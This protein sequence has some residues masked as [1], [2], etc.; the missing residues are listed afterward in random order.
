MLVILEG[1]LSACKPQLV[2]YSIMAPYL[3]RFYP[4]KTMVHRAILHQ[5]D[6]YHRANCYYVQNSRSVEDL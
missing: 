6:L 2:L 3:K 1:E 4:A 5:T